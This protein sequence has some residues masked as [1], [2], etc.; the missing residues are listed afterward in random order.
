LP[1]SKRPGRYP[2]PLHSSK[3]TDQSV[4]WGECGGARCQPAVGEI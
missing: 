4:S 2:E 1:G 3:K